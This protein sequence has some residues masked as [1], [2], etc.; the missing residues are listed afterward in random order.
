MTWTC[1]PSAWRRSACLF[2][3]LLA[4]TGCTT[5]PVPS[6]EAPVAPETSSAVAGETAEV[7][8]AVVEA[9]DAAETAEPAAP[10]PALRPG[11]PLARSGDEIVVAGQ[12]FHTGTPVV[13]WTDPGGY[14]G[15][16]VER[17]FAPWAESDW[18]RSKAANSALS[19]PNRFG[20]RAAVLTPPEKIGRA[21]V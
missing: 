12:L 21:H 13:L 10:A 4:W 18:D 16:R 19:T 5:T 20:L 7:T 11:E 17:R 6:E 1:P 3:A 8:A 2:L 15:Y 14:D 9:K